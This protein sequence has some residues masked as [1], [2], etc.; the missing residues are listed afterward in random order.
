MSYRE[1][2]SC[3]SFTGQPIHRQAVKGFAIDIKYER[4]NEVYHI[5][6]HWLG[7]RMIIFAKMEAQNI[8]AIYIYIKPAR[9]GVYTLDSSH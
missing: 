5:V 1:A 7:F 6:S 2:R 9:L 4:E 8:W 3:E